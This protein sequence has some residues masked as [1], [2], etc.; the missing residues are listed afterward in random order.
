MQPKSGFIKRQVPFTLRFDQDLYDRVKMTSKR[1]GRS[2]TAYVQEAVA[3]RLEE[4]EAA[5]LFQAFTLVGEDLDEASMEYAHVA[6]RE[7]AL[8][9]E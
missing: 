1:E 8:K 6:Q 4:E 9:G 3:R 5:S 7:V 2:I